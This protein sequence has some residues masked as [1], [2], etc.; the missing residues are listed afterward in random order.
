LKNV[1]IA[2]I[3]IVVLAIGGYFIY[4]ASYKSPTSSS[5]SS[6]QNS[7]ATNSINI[8]NFA[9]T[10]QTITIKLGSTVTWTNSDSVT[11]N[12]VGADFNANNISQGQTF[13]HTF[14]TAGTFDY[15]CS[16]HPEM[17]GKVIVQ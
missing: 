10:P 9:F 1:L 12:P 6:S 11:H 17:T 15:H 16:I 13:K 7:V 14:N 3:V 5:N 8:V 4:K 2:I